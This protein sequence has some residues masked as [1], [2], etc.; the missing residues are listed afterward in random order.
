VD[1]YNQNHYQLHITH[2]FSGNLSAN[3]SANYTSGNGYFEQYKE[4]EEL[5]EY[6]PNSP[7]ADQEGD[8]I[9][10]RWLDNKYYA[11]IY[12]LNYHT[13]KLDAY[14]GGGLTSYDGDHFGEVVWDSF[15]EDVQTGSQ[16]YFSNGDKR[17]FNTYIKAEYKVTDK[18]IIF[19]DLQQ[20]L[21][22]YQTQ[23]LSSDVLPIDVDENYAFFNPKVGLT[24]ALQESEIIYGSVAVGNREPNVMI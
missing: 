11:L 8:V 1:D 21:I 24:F 12:S 3:I 6:F 2:R 13:P 10:R 9:R 18:I 7:N 20:R 17:D 15:Q 4:A 14:F 5:G 22:N 19:G 16:Y 23:G